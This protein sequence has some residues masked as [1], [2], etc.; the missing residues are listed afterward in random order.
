MLERYKRINI[1]MPKKK[2]TRNALKTIYATLRETFGGYTERDVFI[3]SPANGEWKNPDNDEVFF[4]K[5]TSID[6]DVK[7]SN[8]TRIIQ[9]LTNIKKTWEKQFGQLELW[10]TV[11]AIVRIV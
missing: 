3:I 8:I 7:S 11:Q 9:F 1:L 5:H 10:I 2:E 6:V 4:D